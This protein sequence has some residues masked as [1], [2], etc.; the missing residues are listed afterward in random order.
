MML[1]GE[2]VLHEPLVRYRIGT[3][4]SSALYHHRKP[5]VKVWRDWGPSLDQAEHDL[6]AIA[7]RL[8]PERVAE[9]RKEFAFERARAE[10]HLVLLESPSF[11][12]RWRA[13]QKERREGSSVAA[14]FMYA[15]AELVEPRHGVKQ[16]VAE[17]LWQQIGLGGCAA[18]KSAFGGARRPAEPPENS[19]PKPRRKMV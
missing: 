6:A 18:F 16:Q 11:R 14:P 2:L 19:R 10:N 8:P 15:S 13:F 3:G 4:V 7:D 17:P 5:V 12:A 9:F 1:G